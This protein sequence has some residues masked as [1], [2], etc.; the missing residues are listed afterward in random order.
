MEGCGLWRDVWRC[1]GQSCEHLTFS[2]SVLTL[3]QFECQEECCQLEWWYWALLLGWVDMVPDWI[4]SK[5]IMPNHTGHWLFPLRSQQVGQW[6]SPAWWVGWPSCIPGLWG[7]LLWWRWDYTGTCKACRHFRPLWTSAWPV[8]S[9]L[10]GLWLRWWLWPDM[11]IEISSR[12]I[13]IF[14]RFSLP[15]NIEWFFCDCHTWT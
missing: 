4:L 13:N 1:H 3:P 8:V 14:A 11:W 7:H 6:W 10:L 5:V 9:F 15:E 12:K 2:S